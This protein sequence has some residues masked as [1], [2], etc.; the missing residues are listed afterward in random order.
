VVTIWK[1]EYFYGRTPTWVPLTDERWHPVRVPSIDDATRLITQLR[2]QSCSLRR[3]EYLA[4]DYGIVT[5]SGDI[6]PLGR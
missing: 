5:A 4:P 6:V 3:G 1:R 2:S